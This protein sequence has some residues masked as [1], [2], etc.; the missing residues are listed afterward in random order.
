GPVVRQEIVIDLPTTGHVVDVRTGAFL[1]AA[2]RLKASVVAGDAL[3]LA[4]GSRAA[5]V[6]VSG[7][8]TASRGEHP[9]VRVTSSGPCRRLVA[10]HVVGPDGRSRPE[11]ARNLILDAGEATLVVP[12]ALDDEPGPYRVTAVDILSGTKAEAP[13]LLR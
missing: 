4:V 2:P 6:E 10:G 8:E 13:L 3:V 7:P 9:R 12:S 11:Y 5:R 1:G